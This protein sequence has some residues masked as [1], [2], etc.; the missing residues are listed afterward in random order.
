MAYGEQR[1][2]RFPPERCVTGG[3]EI[4]EDIALLLF[5]RRHHRQHTFDETGADRT[6]CATAPLTPQHTGA[7]RPLSRIIGRLDA[8]NWHERPQCLAA[9]E[10]VP[11]RPGSLGHPAATPRI[12]EPF[13]F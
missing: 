13:H 8:S 4:R 9:L 5:Q 1:R 2:S 10:D 6:L 11:T 3:S 12:Q 7:D